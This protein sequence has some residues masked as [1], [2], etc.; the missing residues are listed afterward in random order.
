MPLAL[1]LKRAHLLGGE[2]A[3]QH[4][5]RREKSPGWALSGAGWLGKTKC[6]FKMELE[7]SAVA[8]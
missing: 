4:R 7:A 8:H 2:A 5:Q 6:E 1:S 3:A